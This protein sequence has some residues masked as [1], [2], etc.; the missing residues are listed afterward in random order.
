MPATQL[1]RTFPEN[2]E[3]TT[4]KFALSNEADDECQDLAH[5]YT[6]ELQQL[7][8]LEHQQPIIRTLKERETRPSADVCQRTTPNKATS[9]TDVPDDGADSERRPRRRVGVDAETMAAED[10]VG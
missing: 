5:Q 4:C 9:S 7:E 8:P 1:T 3:R 6:K 10:P 2:A